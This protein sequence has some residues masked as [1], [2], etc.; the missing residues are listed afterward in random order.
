MYTLRGV[1]RKDMVILE[2]ISYRAWLRPPPI[3]FFKDYI[4][5]GIAPLSVYITNNDYSY[6]IYIQNF[7]TVIAILMELLNSHASR[8]STYTHV[9]PKW[10]HL[11]HLHIMPIHTK[12]VSENNRRQKSWDKKVENKKQ[13][14]NKYVPNFIWGT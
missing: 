3:W 12:K 9:H 7:R 13:S 6:I 14:K 5:F 2:K 10:H 11:A 1:I 4:Y 8:T